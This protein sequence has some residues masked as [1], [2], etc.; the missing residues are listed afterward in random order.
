[1]KCR[2]KQAENDRVWMETNR[3]IQ[4]EYAL[5]LCAVMDHFHLGV[6]RMNEFM[7]TV[8]KMMAEYT[9]DTIDGRLRE[10]LTEHLESK[11]IDVSR[12]F[13]EI[14][15]YELSKEHYR[16]SAKPSVTYAEAAEIQKYMNY[17]GRVK[18]SDYI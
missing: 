3:V 1:M 15:G 9:Q 5:V 14:D 8:D 10:K 11:N 12:I 13:T 17:L 7:D 18:N 6:K 16:K 4:D 2:Y